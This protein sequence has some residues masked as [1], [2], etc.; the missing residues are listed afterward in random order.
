LTRSPPQPQ[1][2][3]VSSVFASLSPFSSSQQQPQQ[4]K[5]RRKWQADPNIQAFLAKATLIEK[6]KWLNSMLE[7]DIAIQGTP[8]AALSVD[9]QAFEIVL[10]AMAL[11]ESAK[12]DPGVP[13]RAE[14]WMTRL[15]NLSVSSNHPE[16]QPTVACYQ[17][18]IQAWANSD[19]EQPMVTVNRSERW[20]KQL[21]LDQCSTEDIEL[22]LPIVSPSSEDQPHLRQHQEDNRGRR[23]THGFLQPTIECF[24]AFL[25]CC[26]RGRTGRNKKSQFIVT[27]NARK[28]EAILRRLISY[29]HHYHE[30]ASVIF[31]T[32]TCNLVIRG[33]TRCK[34][35]DTIHTRVL[36]ILRLMESYQR[37]DP[38]HS[39]VKADTKSYSMALD[40]LVSVAKLKARDNYNNN[41]QLHSK[42]SNLFYTNQ[43]TTSD[44]PSYQDDSSRN[45]MD[46]L[47]EAQ[48]IL[49]YMHN[50]YDAGVE[51]V[52][53]HRVPYNI[54][55]TGWA[56]LSSYSRSDGKGT[57]G[58]NTSPPFK[59]E[60]IL[61][62]MQRHRDNGFF[63][64]APD[65][66]SYEK[67]ITAWANSDHP[68]AGKRASW[69]LKQLWNEHHRPKEEKVSDV[70]LQPTVFTY[71]AVL[72]AL[73]STE[74]A[75]A[76][77]NLL[78]DLGI[79]YQKERIPE[80]C[81]NSESFALVIR[82]WLR[83][84]DETTNVDR[85]VASLKRAVEWLSSLR[86]IENEKNLSSAPELYK[87]VLRIC[88]IVA[89]PDR[90]FILDIA[91][92]VF[93]DFRQSRHRVDY[94]S[95]AALLKVGLRVYGNAELSMDRKEFVEALFYECCNDGQVSNILL[96]TLSN[97][98]S[99]EC[100]EMTN[101][102]RQQWP[103]PQ[104]WSRN[105]KNL[106][107][108][109]VARDLSPIERNAE[110]SQKHRAF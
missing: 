67:V 77:E 25:D 23:R 56:G 46:E 15:L 88:G 60:E 107:A 30:Q 29:Y 108:L 31:N 42:N 84:A 83:S 99:P 85:R 13:R 86:Q 1:T 53:P 48:E 102:L 37:K 109:A 52:V 76:A 79:V 110:E 22:L 50:L 62:T 65:V 49:Q 43:S 26:T 105:L 7:S 68:N 75:L 51:G 55:I 70:D 61:R 96:R 11:P 12:L 104:S 80:L 47:E 2:I 71:N 19:K 21:L 32:E 91:Q 35:D 8:S 6:E 16:L 66:I 97:D 78:L 106:L 9:V 39:H 28:A 73:A 93:Q 98:N 54:L 82:A 3:N 103:L 20:L 33:W 92:D 89:H 14:S 72:K 59:A 81:P 10:K 95:Y 36:S 94:M 27:E 18:V 63:E 57:I 90:P 45:G 24:N 64:A 17:Y 38:L 100:I 58:S 74:G 34:H 101:L 40:A 87:G 69:W 41:V 5:D 4:Q 44:P